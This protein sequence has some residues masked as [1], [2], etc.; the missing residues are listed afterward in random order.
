MPQ[1]TGDRFS[2]QNMSDCGFCPAE[3]RRFRTTRQCNQCGRPLCLSCRPEVPEV[4]YLCPE[5]GGGPSEDAIHHPEQ[6]IGKIQAGGRAAPYWLLV[7]HERLAAAPVP[8][9]DELIA[10]E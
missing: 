7:L 8:D 1:S 4:S 6:A 2:S 3:G 5:C 10:P 9:A